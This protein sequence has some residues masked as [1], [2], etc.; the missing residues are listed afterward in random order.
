MKERKH[1]T[2]RITVRLFTGFLAGLL[3]LSLAA[4][5]FTAYAQ[6]AAD[7]DPNYEPEPTV[8]SENFGYQKNGDG[9]IT[10]TEYTGHDDVI[11][12]PAEIDGFLVSG[13]GYRAFSN[14]EMKSLSIPEEVQT[15]EENAFE[16][17]VIS[18]SITL[19]SD[20]VIKE[21]AFSYVEFPAEVTI[22][23]G[24]QLAERSFEYCKGVE[25][26]LLQAGVTVKEHAFGY[27][28]HLRYVICAAGVK[29]ENSAFDYCDT[30]EQVILCGE[31][32]MEEESVTNNDS[33]EI[34]YA[35]E[36]AFDQ[37]PEELRKAVESTDGTGEY[38]VGE[39]TF[40]VP[41]DMINTSQP[42]YDL[43]LISS[44]MDCMIG[45]A[46]YPPSVLDFEKDETVQTMV[47]SAEDFVTV[48][49]AYQVKICG[50]PAVWIDMHN[51]EGSAGVYLYISLKDKMYFL[52][53]VNMTGVRGAFYEIAQSIA[54]GGESEG[55]DLSALADSWRR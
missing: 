48:D 40:F 51:D 22:P 26:L 45:A 50:Y 35:D 21:Q 25:M 2:N 18:D 9:T 47:K 10:I 32:D 37:L 28:K 42:G 46:E 15:I 39:M 3:I 55:T 29:L 44:N 33:A 4:G 53:Y 12:I 7:M 38:A 54:I 1:R 43:F 8:N 34:V 49:A 31:V 11:A 20:I 16:Y 17:C 30:L 24:A 52:T 14:Y 36:E 41:F 23:S 19:P 27:S 6:G 13:I 5:C